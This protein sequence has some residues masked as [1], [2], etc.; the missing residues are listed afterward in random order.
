MAMTY[1]TAKAALA[2]L[3]TTA[4]LACACSGDEPRNAAAARRGSIVCL[5]NSVTVGFGLSNPAEAFPALLA[6]MSGRTVVNAGMSGD[7][8]T[9][10][11]TRIENEVLSHNPGLVIVELGGNDYLKQLPLA[12]T[13]TNLSAIITRL[14]KNGV[15]VAVVDPGGPVL[16]R[17]YSNAFAEVAKKQNALFFKHL[18]GGIMLKPELKLDQVHP[19][20]EGHRQLAVLIYR[21]LKKYLN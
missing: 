12:Q 2:T 9:D 3:C 10:A 17:D 7:T 6:G 20:A 14:Q 4:F 16:L 13:T 21:D 8:T 5:G 1:R 18:L 11:L 15:M 19:N